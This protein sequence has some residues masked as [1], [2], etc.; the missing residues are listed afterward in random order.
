MH[1]NVMEWCIDQYVPDYF[2]K[3]NAGVINAGVVN[4][5]I[6]P[7]DLYPRS[8]RGGGWD[9]DPEMLRSAARRGS[10][11]SWKQQDPQLPKSIWYHTNAPW[12]GFRIVRPEKIPT[13]EEMYFYWNL[14]TGAK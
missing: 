8:V 2:A 4:P 10:D 14:A 7:L 13:P 12:L 5:V 9:D 1:G 3:I 6:E 11:K